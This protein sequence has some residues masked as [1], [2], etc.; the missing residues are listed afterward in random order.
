MQQF[1]YKNRKQLIVRIKLRG[2]SL[3]PVH[4]TNQAKKIITAF[5]VAFLL[6]AKMQTPRPSATPLFFYRKTGGQ[7]HPAFGDHPI[8]SANKGG[9]KQELRLEIKN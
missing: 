7:E 5:P 9:R 4:C 1:F 6:F 2:E 8:A 3:Q